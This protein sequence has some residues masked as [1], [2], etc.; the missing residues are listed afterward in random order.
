MRIYLE[1]N[2]FLLGAG[3]DID[4]IDFNR[5]E[6][7]LRELL[8]ALSHRSPDSPEFFTPGGTDLSMGWTVE[9]NGN[10]LGLFNVGLETVLRDGDRVGIKLDLICGG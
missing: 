4:S 2:F 5:P 1:S 3:G 10:V 7:T 8:E 6:M 9:V